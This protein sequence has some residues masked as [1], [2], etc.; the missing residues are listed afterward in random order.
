MTAVV[1]VLALVSCQ[2]EDNP[3]TPGEPANSN[4]YNVYFSAENPSSFVIGLSDN[5]FTIIVDRENG[6][7]ALSVP[8]ECS[9][10]SDIFNFPASIDFAAGEITKEITISFSGADPFVSYSFELKIPEEYTNP[11]KLVEGYPAFS[12]SMLQEDYKVVATG[13]WYDDFWTGETWAQELEYSELQDMY[14]FS[15][16]WDEGY[17]FTF[18]WDKS[19]NKFSSLPGKMETGIVSSSYGMIS[20][21][22]VSFEYDAEGNE[23]DMLFK[24]TVSAGSFGNYYNIFYFD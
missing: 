4:G 24:W 18:K 10:E 22:A 20:A 6:G 3:Y 9:S 2:K 15:N 12:A 13:T 21:T 19:T 11:Y 16:V 5:Q 17:G 8:I 23:I 7:S 14:R 1:A